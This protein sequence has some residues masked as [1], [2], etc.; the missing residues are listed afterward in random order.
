[1]AVH[2]HPPPERPAAPARPGPDLREHD[3]VVDGTTITAREIAAEMQH[4][5]ADTAEEAW[6]E[7]ARALVVRRL[8]LDA[9]AARG[10]T[11]ADEPGEEAID[12]LLAAELRPPEPDEAACRRWHAAHPERFGAPD[13]W[14]ASHILL[15]ADPE[16]APARDSAQARAEELLALVQADPSRLP[17]LARAHSDC[18]SRDQGGHLGHIE[19]GSTVPE[20]ETFLAGLEPGQVCPVVVTSRYGM[21]V[22]HLHAH[23][24]ARRLTFE[25][26]APEV[27]ADLR[28]AAWHTAARQFVAVLVGRARIEGIALEG[29]GSPLVQ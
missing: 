12:A 13:L 28:R 2:F 3:V 15:A 25:A 17:G 18:P 20:F 1:M 14:E 21:H 22:L 7:A 27:A 24:P 16:D 23:A 19:R 6:Q 9:A 4:H 11:S 26:A 29:S 5:P 10:L 8:L